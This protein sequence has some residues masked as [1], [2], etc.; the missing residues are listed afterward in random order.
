MPKQKTRSSATKRLKI[1]SKGKLSMRQGG[2]RHN[3]SNMT[4]AKKR[5]KRQMVGIDSAHAKAA[6]K[7]AGIG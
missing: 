7:A 1:S 4:G 2:I 6:R 5:Q 3:F